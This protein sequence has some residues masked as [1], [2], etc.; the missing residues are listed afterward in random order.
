MPGTQSKN[1]DLITPDFTVQVTP[2][3]NNNPPPSSESSS[4]ST[5][6]QLFFT[7]NNSANMSAK[8][9]PDPFTIPNP[10][11]GSS[12]ANNAQS[13]GAASTLTPDNK[14]TPT[15]DDLMADKVNRTGLGS[16]N[17]NLLKVLLM[18][19]LIT[20]PPTHQKA[21]S[22]SLG[23]MVCWT[24]LGLELEPKLILDGVKLKSIQKTF[25]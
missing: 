9:T 16:V 19:K 1:P 6:D 15:L 23:D 24:K 4:D 25:C 18:K 5:T 11:S 17:L 20:E 12:Q 2:S 21:T 10:A 13:Q 7:I 3:R 22:S 8:P 14:P